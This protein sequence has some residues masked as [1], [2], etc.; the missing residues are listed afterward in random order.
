MRAAHYGHSD[1]VRVLLEAGASIEAKDDVS[2]GIS[3]CTCLC[4]CVLY[5]C[6]IVYDMWKVLFYSILI[7]YY[8]DMSDMM[9]KY[10]THRHRH[11]QMDIPLLTLF[12]ASVEAPASSNTLTVSEW[13]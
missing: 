6:I 2:K 5:S 8:C 1:T 7:F 11:V 3:I 12:F 4:L 9:Q 13:P 10:N